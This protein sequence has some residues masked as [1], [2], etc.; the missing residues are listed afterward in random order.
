MISSP[1]PQLWRWNSVI[2]VGGPNIAFDSW[3]I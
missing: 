3:L 2:D 1:T